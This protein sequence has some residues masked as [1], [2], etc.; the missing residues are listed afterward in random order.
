[1]ETPAEKKLSPET[2]LISTKDASRES[3]APLVLQLGNSDQG[4]GGG[5]T[6]GL[7]W[8]SV[9]QRL[10]LTIPLGIILS[11]AASGPLVLH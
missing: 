7:I 4:T 5:V 2:T 10:L 9:S 1:M 11:A 6:L 3:Q 8:K